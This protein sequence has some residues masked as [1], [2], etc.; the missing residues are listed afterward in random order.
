MYL[1]IDLEGGSILMCKSFI[2]LIILVFTSLALAQNS[3]VPISKTHSPLQISINAL[4]SSAIGQAADFEVQFSS[5]VDLTGIRV[6]V[7]PSPDVTV[8]RGELIWQ[9]DLISGEIYRFQFNASVPL[10]V[11][12]YIQVLAKSIP[13]NPQ[14]F[15]ALAE[16]QPPS[17]NIS[18]AIAES[19]RK[20]KTVTRSGRKVIEYLLR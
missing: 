10:G 18:N 9:G 3:A 13:S 7:T 2:V 11:N 20:K 19:A 15:A 6:S 8:H 16:Y 12:A 1:G 14:H 4:T 5:A 17:I